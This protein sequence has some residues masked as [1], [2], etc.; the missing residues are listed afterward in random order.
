MENQMKYF[1]LIILYAI[2][3]SCS[4]DPELFPYEI[5]G[6][7]LERKI[8]GDEAKQ[9]V[10]KLHINTVTDEKNEIAFYESINGRA[11]IYATFYSNELD[12]N[13]NMIRMAK[14][15]SPE[16]SVFSKGNFI[17]LNGK[18]IY[19]TFG[20]GQ[21][22]F[23]FVHKKMLFWVSIDIGLAKKFMESYLQYFS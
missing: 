7:Q 9:F 16:N 23:V 10:N 4:S 6:M 12:A 11:I 5:T 20:M 18:R 14:K 21:E 8:T 2:I 22:H 17:E 3:V 13:Q 1:A 15:I 19:H